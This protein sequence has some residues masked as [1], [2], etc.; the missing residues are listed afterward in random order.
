[1]PTLP[2]VTEQTGEG[3]HSAVGE[4]RGSEPDEDGSGFGIMAVRYGTLVSCI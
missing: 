2:N 1:M 3:G 4:C